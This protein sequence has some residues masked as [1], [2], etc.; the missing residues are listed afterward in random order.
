MSGSLR[1]TNSPVTGSRIEV[2]LDIA[3]NL[4]LTTKLK[5]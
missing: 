3:G 2:H 5:T 4:V 1:L